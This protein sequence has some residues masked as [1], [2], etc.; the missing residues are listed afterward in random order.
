M[1][2]IQLRGHVMGGA[3]LLFVSLAA[4]TSGTPDLPQ[5]SDQPLIGATSPS[6][7]A[8]AG[9]ATST[10]EPSAAG[11]D[12]EFD[13]SS[14][15]S[16]QWAVF[17]QSG[18]VS[19]HDGLL[20]VVTPPNVRNCPYIVTKSNV[21]PQDGPFFFETKY[22]R[23]SQGLIPAF[24][25]DYLPAPQPN[26]APVTQPFMA[27]ATSGSNVMLVFNLESGTRSYVIPNGAVIGATH[28]IRLEDDGSGNYRAIADET[29]L[30]TFHSDRRPM[31]FWIG[32]NPPKDVAPNI[33]AR[34]TFDY[35]KAAL[36]T[37]PDP[38][39]PASGASS[40]M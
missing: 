18:V 9:D 5:S 13:G 11:F 17:S 10:Q 6:P 7:S 29:E 31:K 14:L 21:I 28:R 20:D 3:L 1:K 19:V 15:D 26:E 33:W 12:N 2:Q 36:L 22:T 34:M 27:L 38:A 37:V 32:T 30:G 25:L 40:T 8:S 16:T 39:M 4:C 24:C 35:V 23:M